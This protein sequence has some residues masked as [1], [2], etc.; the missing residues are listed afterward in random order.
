MTLI[1]AA[2]ETKLP[3]IE[4]KNIFTLYNNGLFQKK[5]HHLPDGWGRFLTPLSPGLREV[6]DFPSC[7]D[8]QD[9]RTPPPYHLD[10]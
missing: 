3:V 6:Q 5:K 2:K 1:M 9:K 10:F 4:N 7:Q 8:F